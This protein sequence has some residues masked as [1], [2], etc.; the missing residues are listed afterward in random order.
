MVR[1]ASEQYSANTLD[2]FVLVQMGLIHEPLGLL[3]TNHRPLGDQ[4]VPWKAD[5]W[6]LRPELFPGNFMQC[7]IILAIHLLP[8][9]RV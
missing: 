8:S 6:K 2:S 3:P 4:G 9:I 5:P 7:K 1:I